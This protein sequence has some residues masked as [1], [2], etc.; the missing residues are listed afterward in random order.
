MK[1]DK[2]IQALNKLTKEEKEILGLIW[3]VLY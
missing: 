3:K 1:E 2:R